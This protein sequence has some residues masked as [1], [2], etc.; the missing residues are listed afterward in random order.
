MQN[1]T[2]IILS[3]GMLLEKV[4]VSKFICMLLMKARKENSEFV[5]TTDLREKVRCLL[6]NF[7]QSKVKP[8]EFEGQLLQVLSIKTM[9]SKEFWAEWENILTVGNVVDKIQR[10]QQAISIYNSF[11][12]N[13]NTFAL[14]YLSSNTNSVHL[15]KIKKEVTKQNVVLNTIEKRMIFGTFP[16]YTSCQLHK[17]R[18]ELTM[19]IV[20]AIKSKGFNKPNEII[21]IL[22][23]PENL[24]EKT[25][26]DQAK[27]ECNNIANW[28][29]ENKV[30]VKLHNHS[31]GETVTQILNSDADNIRARTYSFAI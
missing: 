19:H 7:N 17:N 16:L 11:E 25:L 29:K 24:P 5:F 10:L 9:Q 14:V 2:V 18:Q 12:L 3:L 27:M 6:E 28:C 20:E 1:R 4:D 22:G 23:N 8:D 13:R 31:L 30:S 15:E 26:R 21:L